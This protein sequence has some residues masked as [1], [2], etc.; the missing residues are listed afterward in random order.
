MQYVGQKGYTEIGFSL[1]VF[2]EKVME[3]AYYKNQIV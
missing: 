1:Y 2:Q 3:L